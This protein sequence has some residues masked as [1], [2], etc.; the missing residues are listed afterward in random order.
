MYLDHGCQCFGFL[1]CAQ[2]LMHVIAHRGCMNS[3]Q[4]ATV[5]SGSTV[6]ISIPSHCDPGCPSHSRWCWSSRSPTHHQLFWLSPGL[7][8]CSKLPL[9]R[10]Q[11]DLAWLKNINSACKLGCSTIQKGL[12]LRTGRFYGILTVTSHFHQSWTQTLLLGDFL[13]KVW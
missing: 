10:L 5:Q 7:S 12:W 3:V 6:K 4:E 1:T 13:P 8:C 9:S 11:Q 2:M